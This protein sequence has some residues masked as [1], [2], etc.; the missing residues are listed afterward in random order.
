MPFRM[1]SADRGPFFPPPT[2]KRKNEQLAGELTSRMDKEGEAAYR[3]NKACDATVNSVFF[4]ICFQ[5]ER[6]EDIKVRNDDGRRLTF[7]LTRS[8]APYFLG[9][10]RRYLFFSGMKNISR[11]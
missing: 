6:N 11:P 5:R 10:K 8:L 9:K 7:F 3:E 2:N 1:R 4:F